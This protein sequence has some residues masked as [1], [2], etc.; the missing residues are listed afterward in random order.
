MAIREMALN[1]AH[2]TTYTNITTNVKDTVKLTADMIVK[3]EIIGVKKTGEEVYDYKLNIDF[4]KNTK[5][6]LNICLDEMQ[7]LYRNRNFMSKQNKIISEWLSMLRRV[8]GSNDSG[9]GQL[10]CIS[11]R[12]NVDIDLRDLAT[13]IQYHICHYLKSCKRCG[14]TWS[15]NS[16]SPDPRWTCL[17]CNNWQIKKHSH[18]VEVYYFTDFNSY[19]FWKS[20]GMKTY[21]DHRIFADVEKYMGLYSSEAW[22]TMFVNIF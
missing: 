18:R 17:R 15:E 19:N 14:F 20:M 4:W 9:Y 8:L 6:P 1:P 16:D 22:E 12:P 5:K 7:N 21:Y 2:R 3:K 13:N 11:Q 10:V